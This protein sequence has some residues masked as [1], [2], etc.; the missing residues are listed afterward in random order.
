MFERKSRPGILQGGLFFVSVFLIKISPCNACYACMETHTCAIKDD[1]ADLSVVLLIGATACGNNS[2]QSEGGQG[3]IGQIEGS[4]GK[5]SAADLDSE[6]VCGCGRS[7]GV[8]TG[9]GGSGWA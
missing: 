1:M 9:A 3:I 6:P 2:G 7:G 5:D 4:S 8:E